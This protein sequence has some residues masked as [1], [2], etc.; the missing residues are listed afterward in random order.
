MHQERRQQ[1]LSSV[2]GRRVR[3]DGS[4][5]R[6]VR[7]RCGQADALPVAD[8]AT[9]LHFDDRKGRGDRRHSVP[10]IPRDGADVSTPYSD[11]N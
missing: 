10:A 4:N 11:S 8:A 2:P 1:R 5:A 9:L 6:E 3:L 7:R